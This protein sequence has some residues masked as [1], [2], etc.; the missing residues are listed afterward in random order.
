MF[1]KQFQGVH[2]D[3]IWRLDYMY[4]SSFMAAI[5]DFGGHIGFHHQIFFGTIKYH[6]SLHQHD[7]WVFYRPHLN[8][9]IKKTDF[10]EIRKIPDRGSTHQAVKSK[11]YSISLAIILKYTPEIHTFQKNTVAICP[12]KWYRWPLLAQTLKQSLLFWSTSSHTRVYSVSV[13]FIIFTLTCLWMWM[14]CYDWFWY[15]FLDSLVIG[16]SHLFL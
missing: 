10:H 9:K 12:P 2:M 8:A 4:F 3:P 14:T 15:W 1:H 11:S 7:V 5:L 16:G 6:I 13:T